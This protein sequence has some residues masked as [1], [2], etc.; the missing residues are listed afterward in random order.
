MNKLFFI[1]GVNMP[2]REFPRS[3]V[4]EDL[5]LSSWPAIEAQ[6]KRLE[7]RRIRGAKGL[8]RWLLDMSELLACVNEEWMRLYIAMTTQTDDK[9]RERA[10][11]DFV[12]NIQ[13]K[14]RFA[15]LRLMRKYTKSSARKL[16]PA[17]RF[18]VLDSSF[19]NRVELF[20]RKNLRLEVREEKL[21]QRYQKL[22]GAMAVKFDGKERTLQQMG[23]YLEEPD[24]ETRRRAWEGVAKRRLRDRDR[25]EGLFDKLFRLRLEMAGNAGFDDYIEYTFRSKERFDYTVD[26]CGKFHDAVEKAVVPAFHG[27]QEE[28]RERLGVDGLRPWDLNVDPEGAPPLRPFKDAKE[29]VE[30]AGR[31][32]MR[33]DPELGA[34]FAMMAENDLLDLE[35]R[36]GKAPGGYC[37]D[38]QER[39][40]PFIFMNAAGLDR[41]VNTLIHESGHSFH[42]L[43]CR[44]EPLLHYRFYPSEA[45]EVASMGME[46]LAAPFLE[47]FYS[48]DDARRSRRKH[49]EQIVMLLPWIATIDS[50]QQWLYTHTGHTREDR[51]NAWLAVKKKF[52]GIEDFS[53]YEDA[54]AFEWHRQLHIFLHPFYYIEYGIAQLGALELWQKAMQDREEALAKYKEALA[55]GGS[56]PL[57]EFFRTAG[58]NFDF[59]EKR[60]KKLVE[61]VIWEIRR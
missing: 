14:L 55:L 1:Q 4:P 44:Q 20:N 56:R 9:D 25:I 49:L 47:E 15:A 29:L 6:F 31:V 34:Q 28:R 37:A 57:P 41:D 48:E 16:L 21:K 12:Q 45:A 46:L 43:A 35:S 58:L 60:I 30:K 22:T 53:G 2:K 18:R 11:L 8:E 59:S 32:F 51:R 33:L 52:G 24:R 54:L 26:D 3:F 10:Y 61:D 7:S 38:Y 5:D 13:P 17:D 23:R 42:N 19:S 40:L 39:R 36:K 27:L 50:F